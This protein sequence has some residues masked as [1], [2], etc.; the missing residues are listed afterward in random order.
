MER[1]RRR[2]DNLKIIALEPVRRRDEN[3][4][5]AGIPRAPEPRSRHR[6][7]KQIVAAPIRIHIGQLYEPG[8]LDQLQRLQSRI[9]RHLVHGGG[10][11]GRQPAIAVARN[12]RGPRPQQ[13]IALRHQ[14]PPL[15]QRIGRHDLDHLGPA[16][17]RPLMR[18]KQDLPF[19]LGQPTGDRKGQKRLI[20]ADRRPTARPDHTIRVPHRKGKVVQ[21]GLHL[22]I[23]GPLRR[24]RPRRRPLR[25][26]IALLGLV[27][28]PLHNRGT[29]HAA[30]Q[31]TQKIA[32]VRCGTPGHPQQDGRT[33]QTLQKHVLHTQS[34]LTNTRRP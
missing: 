28:R 15:P 11:H 16:H 27:V 5:G 8:T 14:Q 31:P 17:Q 21:R 33:D 4:H 25:L 34:P 23:G 24:G 3:P 9:P 18:R 13:Q 22:D 29:N 19:H 7:I 6:C 32:I 2:I 12:L 20:F 30:H 26:R 1:C 10:N